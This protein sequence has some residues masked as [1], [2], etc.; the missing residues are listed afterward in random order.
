[1][2]TQEKDMADPQTT[3]KIRAITKAYDEGVNNSDAAA[4]AA[5]YTEDAVFVSDRGPIYGR[6]AIEKWY[7]DVFQAWH[8]KSHIGKPD[9]NAPHIIGTAGDEAWETGEWSETGQGET[10]DPIQIKGYWSAIDSREGDDWKIRMLTY[11]ITP[12][13]PAETK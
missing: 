10:G 7:T 9:G 3:H 13:S 6:P 11:N 2:I 5:L 1:M 8:P 12:A 4:I